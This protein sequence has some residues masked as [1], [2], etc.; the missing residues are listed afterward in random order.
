MSI[1]EQLR[2]ILMVAPRLP[3]KAA[4]GLAILLYGIPVCLYQMFDSGFIQWKEAEGTISTHRG[5]QERNRNGKREYFYSIDYAYEVDGQTFILPFEGGYDD[6]GFAE[7][8]LKETLD[9]SKPATIWFDRADPSEATF[10][11]GR[12]MWPAYLGILTILMLPLLYFRWLMLKYYELEL[13][14]E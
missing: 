11:A 6:R 2:R 10:D 12:M 7:D 1:K 13:E 9:E 3:I 4:M 5:I 14:K 8:K